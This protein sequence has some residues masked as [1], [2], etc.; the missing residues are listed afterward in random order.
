MWQHCF[1]EP[2][3]GGGNGA[4]AQE[5]VGE[6]DLDTMVVTAT[7]TL[8]EIQEVPAAVSVVTAKEIQ[9]KNIISVTEALQTVSGVYMAQGILD[10][11]AYHNGKLV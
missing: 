7:R 1:A 11:L 3:C 4:Q 2:Q 6:F 5:V 10:S 9:E 8:K